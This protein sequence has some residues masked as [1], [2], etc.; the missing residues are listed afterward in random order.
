[1]E[2][3]N[4]IKSFWNERWAK[5][6]TRVPTKQKDYYFSDYGRVK[7]I[8]KVTKKEQLLKGS[9][10]VQGFMLLN[11]RLEGDSTQGCYIHKL[12][13]EEFCPKDNENQKF[14]VHLDQDNLNNHYQNLKWMSQREMTD[15]Q[16]KNG[17]YDPKNRKPS[18]LNKMNPTRVRL[19]KQ[20]LKEGKT[21][22]QILAKNFNITMAQLRKIEKG[23]DWGYITL[24][25]DDNK[26]ST[27]S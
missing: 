16:I 15:F 4:T 14:V 23:I 20:R 18:P 1:M 9:K 7:S 19:L 11:L 6:K 26:S 5:V 17:V 12:V 13:A 10:T 21:K 22:K 24:D 27:S 8:D 2:T 3:T 25:D